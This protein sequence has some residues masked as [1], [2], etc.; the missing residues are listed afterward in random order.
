MSEK[1]R[2][3]MKGC[4]SVALLA[5]ALIVVSCVV[6]NITTDNQRATPAVPTLTSEQYKALAKTISYDSLARNTEAYIGKA[7]YYYKGQVI[8]VVEGRGLR[9]KLRVNVTPDGYGG[10]T[11]TVLVNYEGPRL[12]EGDIVRFWGT[13]EGRYKYKAVLGQTITIPEITAVILDR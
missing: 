2:I 8:Q 10:F 11:D 1:R 5:L 3:V 12:L 7:V 4:L 6:I 9:A 13:V